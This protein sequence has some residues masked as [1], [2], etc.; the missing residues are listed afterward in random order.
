MTRDSWLLW[1]GAIGALI[2]F[3]TNAKVP[4]EWAYGD[5]LQFASFVFAWIMGKLSTSPLKGDAK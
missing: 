2:T 1:L 4:T 3:L 5:W